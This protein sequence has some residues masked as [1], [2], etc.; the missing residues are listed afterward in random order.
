MACLQLFYCV[1]RVHL[2]FVTS[3]QKKEWQAPGSSYCLFTVLLTSPIFSLYRIVRYNPKCT[4]FTT[5]CPTVRVAGVT[6]Q[7]LA[8]LLC[9]SE[10]C[11]VHTSTVKRSLDA[12]LPAS[13]KLY[14][15]TFYFQ[16]PPQSNNESFQHVEIVRWRRH[17][18]AQW[19][20]SKALRSSQ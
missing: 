5:Y 20:S 14:S 16:A 4:V 11:T 18:C 6:S 15:R 9:R 19:R 1:F 7:I 2:R 3:H 8:L 10:Y 12:T 13:K 17:L